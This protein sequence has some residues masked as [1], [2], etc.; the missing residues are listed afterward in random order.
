MLK[1]QHYHSQITKTVRASSPHFIIPFSVV[2]YHQRYST[3]KHVEA[4][5]GLLFLLVFS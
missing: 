3:D 4:L 2:A 1:S 5:I